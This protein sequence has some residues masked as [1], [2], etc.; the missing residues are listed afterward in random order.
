M[1]F[2]NNTKIIALGRLGITSKSIIKVRRKTRPAL[3]DSQIKSFLLMQQYLIPIINNITNY[4]LVNK[5][6]RQPS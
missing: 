5:I 2:S 3:M 6:L 1:V 4:L